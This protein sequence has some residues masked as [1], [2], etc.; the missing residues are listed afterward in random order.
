MKWIK[1]LLL[2]ALFLAVFALALTAGAYFMSRGQPEWY[3]RQPMDPAQLEAAAARAEHQMQRTVSWAQDQQAYAVSSARGAP[4]T[5]PSKSIDITFTQDEL[6]GFF[7]KWD[8]TFGWKSAYSPYISD[9]Q[10]A[11]RDGRLILAAIVNDLGSVVSIELTPHL[12]KD[13]L[14]LSI[15]RV[16]A[17]K[18]PLPTTLL[19]HYR[20]QLESAAAA[21]LPEWRSAAQIAQQGGAN[22]DAVSAAMTRLLIDALHNRPA[23]P[24]LF[25][26]YSMESHPKSLPVKVTGL[27]IE[28]RTLVMTVEPLDPHERATLLEQIRE[29]TAS[30]ATDH[31]TS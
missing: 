5:N 20:Q 17:G 27:R 13:Q 16:L 10:I 9:P 18:L 28:D 25:L 30:T 31:S 14:Y 22:A 29:P 3:S 1:R 24:V 7:H 26:P 23:P 21:Q 15:S 11:L 2:L 8:S 6:N 4:T 19:T 12:E